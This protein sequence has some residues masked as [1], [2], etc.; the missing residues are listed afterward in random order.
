MK[1]LLILPLLLM[2]SF[3]TVYAES[4]YD[5]DTESYIN[6]RIIV[7]V[8]SNPL[9]D[10]IMKFYVYGVAEAYTSTGLLD[11]GINK[12]DLYQNVKKYY[13]DNPL[14]ASKPVIEVILSEYQ[15]GNIVAREQN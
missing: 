5:L 15:G 10:E 8:T 1:R 2:L 12:D 4:D 13:K 11:A 7:A 3:G 9:W 14:D 6:G